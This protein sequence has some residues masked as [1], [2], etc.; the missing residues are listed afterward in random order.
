MMHIEQRPEGWTVVDHTGKVMLVDSDRR[1]LYLGTRADVKAQTLAA[2]LYEAGEGNPGGY[3]AG[4]LMEL[5]T[6]PV[7]YVGMPT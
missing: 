7:K 2:R 4:T 6:T 1:P 5:V 3:P